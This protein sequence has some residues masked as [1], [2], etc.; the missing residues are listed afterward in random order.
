MKLLLLVLFSAIS[1]CITAQITCDTIA[2]VYYLPGNVNVTVRLLD[3]S[4]ITGD[5]WRF[6]DSSL[7][8][9]GRNS[10]GHMVFQY[11]NYTEMHSIKIKRYAFIKG[12]TKVGGA[13]SNFINY[14]G[15][16]YKS[17]FKSSTQALA[18]EASAAVIGGVM[19]TALTKKKFKIKG[20]KRNFA[21]VFEILARSQP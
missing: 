9:Y 1:I 18:V 7:M 8:M 21:P 2:T 14:T 11:I 19:N 20:K 4:D 15:T 13:V 10:A 6:T 16:D 17:D 3:K 5:V 12:A